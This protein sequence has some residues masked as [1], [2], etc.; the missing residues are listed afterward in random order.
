MGRHNSFV[1][2]KD[3]MAAGGGGTGREDDS[4]TSEE[5]T[6]DDR[7]SAKLFKEPLPCF[8]GSAQFWH[9]KSHSMREV[10]SVLVQIRKIVQDKTKDD[11]TLRR[12]VVLCDVLLDCPMAA[13]VP[14]AMVP[15]NSLANEPGKDEPKKGKQPDLKTCL[16]Q[17]EDVVNSLTSAVG[18]WRKSLP[19]STH[20]RSTTTN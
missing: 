18:P 17:L 3:Q 9:P 5:R 2:Q 12:L 1:L 14:E 15:F 20:P 19:K 7:A 13:S 11:P 4:R 10:T 8:K 6:S 16:Q